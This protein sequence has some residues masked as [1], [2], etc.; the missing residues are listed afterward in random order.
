MLIFE[1]HRKIK[2][3]LQEYTHID[4]MTLSSILNVSQVTIRK[5]LEQLEKDGVLTRIHG[6]AILNQD[7]LEKI[8]EESDSL[9]DEKA[10]IGKL[11]SR[12]IDEG[13]IIF[14]GNGNTCIQIAKHI[15][16][17]KN[18]SVITN[19]ISI[20][21]ELFACENIN[22]FGIGGK[23]QKMKGGFYFYGSLSIE[24][25]SKLH[26]HKAFLSPTGVHIQ[27]GYSVSNPEVL[28]LYNAVKAVSD[29]IVMVSDYSKFDKVSMVQFSSLKDMEILVTNENIPVKYKEFFFSAGVELYTTISSDIQDS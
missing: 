21:E 10:M 22:L 12:L 11:A 6:G 15:K 14:L 3:I 26:F 27:Y 18:I 20:I 29:K 28:D 7:P 9:I 19:N 4:V 23:V 16:S 13:N 25:I 8:N 17:I 24:A 5:D 1:R 2:E